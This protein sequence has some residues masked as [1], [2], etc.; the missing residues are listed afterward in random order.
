MS[1]FKLKNEKIDSFKVYRTLT[2]W[3]L[4]CPIAK[5]RSI[6]VLPSHVSLEFID[7]EKE[8]IIKVSCAATKE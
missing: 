8:N 7:P 6:Q 5:R 3:Y 2:H 1:I 4:N